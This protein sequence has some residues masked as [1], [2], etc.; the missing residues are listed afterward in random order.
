MR[1]IA[2]TSGK[3]QPRPSRTA[4]RSDPARGASEHLNFVSVFDNAAP[5]A[6]FI[7]TF[8]RGTIA[9]PFSTPT[10][11]GLPPSPYNSSWHCTG[12]SVL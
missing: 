4:R 6:A 10:H 7:D 8:C 2:A 12:Y 5:A 9:P 1:N 3:A 11:F